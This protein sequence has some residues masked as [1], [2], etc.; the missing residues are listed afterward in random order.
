MSKNAP[1]RALLCPAQ[2]T[3]ARYIVPMSFGTPT[4][5]RNRSLP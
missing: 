4:F 2:E 5:N 1:E 3:F